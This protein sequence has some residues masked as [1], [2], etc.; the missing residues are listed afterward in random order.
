[1]AARHGDVNV[2]VAELPVEALFANCSELIKSIHKVPLTRKYFV[3]LMEK[4]RGGMHA[5]FNTMNALTVSVLPN[6]EYV[7]I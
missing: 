4:S 5:A 3:G 1:M 2:S 6:P 7:D